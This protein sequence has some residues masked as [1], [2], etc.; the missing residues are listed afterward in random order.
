VAT[1]RAAGEWERTQRTKAF[2]PF[3]RYT[4]SSSE[5]LRPEHRSWVGTILPVDDPWWHTHYPPNGWGCKCG[6]RQMTRRQ[7]ERDGYSADA[8]APEVETRS[9][10]D[11][12]NGRRI[13]VPAGIDPGWAQNPGR[14]RQLRAAEFLGDQLERLSPDGR[15]TAIADIVGSRT[16]RDVMANRGKSKALLPVAPL[17][18]MLRQARPTS[19]RHVLL[20]ADSARHI[21]DDDKRRK[22]EPRDFAAAIEIL[23]FPALVK[24]SSKGAVVYGFSDGTGWRAAIKVLPGEVYLTSF[25]RKSTEDIN[26]IVKR[27]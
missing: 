11:N 24:P 22:L 20:S 9:W 4:L 8:A 26:R 7:A 15:R 1:A 16:F 21:I 3:L 6:V 10:F 25:H 27:K 2:L 18:D 14:N 19:A 17:T 13:D 5:R 12:R 23:A